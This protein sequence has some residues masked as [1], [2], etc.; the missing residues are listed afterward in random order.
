[1]KSI[2]LGFVV[3]FLLSIVMSLFKP[4]RK[5]MAKDIARNDILKKYQMFLTQLKCY[6]K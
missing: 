4:T 2:L 6:K 1:M 5:F 3:L